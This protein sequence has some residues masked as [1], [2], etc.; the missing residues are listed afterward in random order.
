MAEIACDAHETQAV[1]SEPS[2]PATRP[3]RLFVVTLVPAGKKAGGVAEDA[4]KGE[5]L[6]A[7]QGWSDVE[8][9]VLKGY[10]GVPSFIESIRQLSGDATI[11]LRAS[12]AVSL[13]AGFVIHIDGAECKVDEA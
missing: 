13:Q 10:M 5:Y 9:A 2:K 7:A 11:T 1:H 3:D 4:R 12:H 8:P 6:V